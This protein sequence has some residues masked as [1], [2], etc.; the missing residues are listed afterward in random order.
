M[1]KGLCAGASA[2]VINI[3]DDFF[4]Y[5]SFKGRFFTGQHDDIY[6]RSILLEQG[7]DRLLFVSIE[8]GDFGKITEWKNKIRQ[9]VDVPEDHIFITVTHDHPSPHVCDDWD[10]EVVDVEKT[11]WFGD[12][13]W[14]ALKRS[15][16]ECCMNMQPARIAFGH[17]SCSINKNRDDPP[18]PR[19]ILDGD[20]HGL[21]DKTVE[22]ARITALDGKTIALFINYSVHGSVMMGVPIKDGG[23]LV[24]GDL[25]GYTSRYVEGAYDYPVVALWTSGAAG[26]QDP[27]YPAKRMKRINGKPEVTFDAGE[28]G[29]IL[30]QVMAEELA[31]EVLYVAD[32]LDDGESDVSIWAMQKDY[33]VPGKV[34]LHRAP[35][36]LTGFSYE[37]APPVDFHLSMAAL[38]DVVFVGI[39]GELVCHIGQEV[40]EALSAFCSRAIV[41]TH[42]NGSLSYISDK[43]GFARFTPES[44]RSHIKEGY[45]E[46]VIIGKAVEMAVMRAGSH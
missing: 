27:I 17:G 3:P 11:A 32:G 43:E 19:R 44:A 10:Q 4:P 40:K 9:V 26:D 22:V 30:V 25:P 15:L 36:D 46:Q 13:V 35:D 42:C 39:P 24:S 38:G 29:Y 34:N 6:V 14:E 1:E 21:S 31:D 5:R 37:D 7:P 20:P 45:A 12:L 16:Q 2:A 8:L 33:T 18:R 23:M 41:V 28:A